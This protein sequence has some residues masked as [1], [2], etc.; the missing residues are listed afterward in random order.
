[1]KFPAHA[2][3]SLMLAFVPAPV[4]AQ[5]ADQ[6]D[7]KIVMV[8]RDDPEMTAAIAQARSSL[9]DFLAL[10]ETPPPGT[11]DFKLKVMIVDG[12]A[13]EHFWVIPFERTTTGFAGVLANEPKL[14]QNVV[15][16]QY[17]KFSRDD[18]S[19]WGYTR[20]GHQVGSFTVCVML[21]KMSK[22][23]ADYVRKQLPLRLLIARLPF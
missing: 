6:G 21:K 12:N 3:L 19:D 10:S 20:N 16:G 2:M 15:N 7:D 22:Q 11:H 5:S 8:A 23:D 17:I 1:M 9:D 4:R 14:V 13:T 18:I